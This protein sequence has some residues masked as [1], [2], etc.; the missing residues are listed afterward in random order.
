MFA[1]VIC[2]IVSVFLDTLYCMINMFNVENYVAMY[3]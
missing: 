1:N 2:S 3:I